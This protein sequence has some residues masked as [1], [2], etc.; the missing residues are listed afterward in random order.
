MSELITLGGS[1]DI[2]KTILHHLTPNSA[3]NFLVFFFGAV[4]LARAAL[5]VLP[6]LEELSESASVSESDPSLFFLDLDLLVEPSF[7]PS[8]VWKAYS[9]ETML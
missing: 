7:F 9:E 8:P 3:S 2:P 5:R 1:R 6:K 4:L